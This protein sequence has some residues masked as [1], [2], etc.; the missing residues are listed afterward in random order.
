MPGKKPRQQRDRLAEIAREHTFPFSVSIS[1]T[2]LKTGRQTYVE[3]TID[4]TQLLHATNENTESGASSYGPFKDVKVAGK[5]FPQGYLITGF[6]RY[7]LQVSPFLCACFQQSVNLLRYQAVV[8]A[9]SGFIRGRTQ[10]LVTYL[11]LSVGHTKPVPYNHSL[12]GS[13]FGH[14]PPWGLRHKGANRGV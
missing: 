14:Q 6:W 5:A 11:S 2:G 7:S 4:A 12:L 8:A 3:D 9:T 13:T 1:N 10:L